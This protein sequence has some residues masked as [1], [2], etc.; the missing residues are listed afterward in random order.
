MKAEKPRKN[1]P[2]RKHQRWHALAMMLML[3][4]FVSTAHAEDDDDLFGDEAFAE[5]QKPKL[6]AAVVMPPFPKAENLLPFDA[7]PADRRSYAL[8][9]KSISVNEKDHIVYYTIVTTSSSGARTINHEGLRC[10]T[11]E[12]KQYAY[13][14]IDGTWARARLDLWRPISSRSHTRFRAALSKDYFCDTGL[15]S[16]T[17]EQIIDRV[18][19]KKPVED[20]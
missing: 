1:K 12:Y 20:W 14:R 6:E 18:K 8:D 7:G 3:L 9:A 17:A 4:S 19:Y 5:R 11:H 15:V 2:V 13:G 10:G 16:G